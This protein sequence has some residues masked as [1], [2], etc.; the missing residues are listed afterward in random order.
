MKK[1]S[2]VLLLAMCAF[3]IPTSLKAIDGYFMLGYGT[4]SK[5]MG[6]TGVAYYKTS[7]IANNP[8]GRAYLGTQ[9]SVVANLMMPSTSYNVMGMPS[10]AAG[11]FPLVPGK[12]ESDINLL[13][14]PNIGANWQI[15]DKSAF[16]F[17]ISGSGIASDYPT[18]TFYDASIENT[19]VNFMQLNFDPSYSY[20]F[21]DKH[22]IGVS[23]ILSYQRFKAEGLS[24]FGMF[25][26]D[27]AKLT[28][29]DIDNSMG[30]GFKI[31]YM[32]ELMD[33]LHLGATY[34]SRTSMG[35]FEEYAGLFAEQGG[36][37]APSNWT[38]GLNYEFSEKLKVLVDYQQINFSEIKAIG[39]PMSKLN[40]ATGAGALGSD[41]GAGFGWKDMSVVK[42]GA[43]FA[44]CESMTIRGG[45]AFGDEPIPSSEVLFNILAPAIN[46][47]HITLGATKT[48]GGEKSKDL[49]LALVY[50]PANTVKGTNP[51]DPAQ[52]IELEMGVFEIELSLTF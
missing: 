46:N 17:S 28:N 5:G 31:G 48:F 16:G 22:S 14:I 24:S 25:S 51:L 34:Q 49:N 32:G 36:F 37:D 23:A 10:G 11:T 20:K 27:A 18:Q 9:Y 30:F 40:P 21:A 41:D 43:E 8:A 7:I 47:Q 4:V 44:A 6:G 50:A 52:E 3:A 15:N 12:V 33:G 42:I 13:F 2:L 26:T 39:N 1:L 45:Y 29:N 35:E 19:G 38:V